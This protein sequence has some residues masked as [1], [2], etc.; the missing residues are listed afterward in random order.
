ML[1]FGPKLIFMDFLFLANILFALVALVFALQNN[2]YLKNIYGLLL[3]NLFLIAYSLIISLIYSFDSVQATIEY[4]KLFVYTLSVFTIVKLY[5]QYYKNLFLEAIF[6]HLYFAILIVMF[7]VLIMFLS[8]NVR[9]FL[10]PLLDMKMA[11]MLAVKHGIRYIDIS[12]G[13]GTTLSLVFF[14][15]F[16]L[17]IHLLKE[18]IIHNIFYSIMPYLFIFAS[19]LV[20]RTGFILIILYGIYILLSNSII[21]LKITKLQI[22]NLIALLLITSLL[23]YILSEYTFIIEKILPWALEFVFSYFESGTI[24]T[25]STN[26]LMNDHYHFNF[27]ALEFVFG[28]NDFTASTDVGYLILLYTNGLVGLITVIA[29]YFIL[30][31]KASYNRSFP[32]TLSSFQKLPLLLFTIIVIVNFKELVFTN[33]RG[34]FLIVL[35]ISLAFYEQSKTRRVR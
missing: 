29:W 24:A 31:K 1:I 12:V 15:G 6:K 33:S 9:D 4:I 34:L 26:N 14:V 32:N 2:N 3:L 8:P 23:V 5:K 7:T 10:L 25:A 20:G 22:Y 17:S 13:A 19:L 16:V 11:D 28:K 27:E 35:L 21:S 30:Y 18:K